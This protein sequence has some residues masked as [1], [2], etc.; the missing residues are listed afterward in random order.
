MDINDKIFI[1]KYT[2]VNLSICLSYPN[3]PTHEFLGDSDNSE[4]IISK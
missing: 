2:H 1:K 3:L 4:D